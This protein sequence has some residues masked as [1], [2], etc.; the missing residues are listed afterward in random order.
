VVVAIVSGDL[1]VCMFDAE[2]EIVVAKAENELIKG[3]ALTA[4]KQQL[5]PLPVDLHLSQEEKQKV[6]ERATS[7]ASRQVINIKDLAQ[8]VL[9]GLQQTGFEKTS[10][11]G[12]EFALEMIAGAEKVRLY[13]SGSTGI[14]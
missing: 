14:R 9:K 5:N 11:S 6:I 2:G 4:L 1:H 3:E 8:D 10:L 12:S 7:I 13:F